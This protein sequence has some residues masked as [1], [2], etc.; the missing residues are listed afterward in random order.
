MTDTT[1]PVITFDLKD[2][3]GPVTMIGRG[4]WKTV[5]IGHSKEVRDADGLVANPT[6]NQIFSGTTRKQNRNVIFARPTVTQD[7]VDTANALLEQ[8][9]K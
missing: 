2:A 6:V 8:A 1:Q 4:P 7:I 9:G 5:T 3:G